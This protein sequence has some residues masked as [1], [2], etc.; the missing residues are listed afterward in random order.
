MK[1]AYLSAST[2][3]S[4]A[5]NSIH[6]MKMCQALAGIGHQV[7]LF[8]PDIRQGVEQEVEDVHSYYGVQPSFPVRRIW[9]SKWLGRVYVSGWLVARRVAAERFDMALARCLPSAWAA[10]RAGVPVLFEYHQ[11]ICDSGRLSR[12]NEW[13]FRRLIRSPRFLGLVVITHTLEAHFLQRYPALKGRIQVAADGADAF[14]ASVE[15]VVLRDRR[16]R[17][18]VGYIGHL[19]PGKGMEVVAELGR[20][21]PGVDFHVVG[22]LD[23]DIEKWRSELSGQSNVQFH[24]FVSHARTPAYIAMLD[25]LL[26][27]NQHRISW[28]NAGGDIAQWTSPLKMFEYMS[29]GKAIVSSDLAVLREVL[30]DNVNALLCPPD[31]IDAWVAALVRLE[32][33]ALRTRLGRRAEADFLAGY[34]W[35]RRA[36]RIM[37]GLDRA[38]DRVARSGNR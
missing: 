35:R 16:D 22:G 18:Q 28:H 37:A 3:P 14:P 13:L 29:A 32:D 21:M 7:T 24:G 1:L 38:F 27:P 30:E 10:A 15:P 23:R 33:P 20:R 25:V 31:D 34:T 9:W 12:L 36:E 19:Y 5:A 2:I 26:L 11:P 6:V 17:L 4:R 8:A